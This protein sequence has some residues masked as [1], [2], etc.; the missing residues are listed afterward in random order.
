MEF[1]TLTACYIAT[2]LVNKTLLD[3]QHIDWLNT[4]NAWVFDMLSPQLD[5]EHT[6]WLRQ[7]T[8]AI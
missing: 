8:R 2:D 1:E 3:Q 6:V 7:K 5:E 4:Y